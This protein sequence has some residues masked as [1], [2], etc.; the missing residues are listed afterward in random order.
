MR[1][2]CILMR[3]TPGIPVKFVKDQAVKVK[4]TTAAKAKEGA[5]GKRSDAHRE[6]VR[7]QRKCHQSARQ[8]ASAWL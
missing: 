2:G 8:R 7:Q 6:L 1:S 5:A 4:E 3:I